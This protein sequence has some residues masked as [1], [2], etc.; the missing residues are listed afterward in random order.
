MPFGG[1]VLL[2]VTHM[3]ALLKKKVR[4]LRVLFPILMLGVGYCLLTGCAAAAGGDS[5]SGA[6]WEKLAAGETQDLIVVF[7]DTAILARASQ[8]SKTKGM[9]FDDA[10]MIRFKS[11]SYAAIKCAALSTFPPGEI[12][13]L[14]HYELLPLLFLRFHSAAALKTLLANP[15]VV[16]AYEDR[17]ESFLPQGLRP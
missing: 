14:K 11:E 3:L 15:L 10:G 2:L 6:V 12:E 1:N 4:I 9:V 13:I 17:P 16:G 7:D 8:L 5:V